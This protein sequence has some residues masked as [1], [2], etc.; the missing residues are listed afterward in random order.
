MEQLT[1]A[2]QKALKT[3]QS[4]Y[5]DLNGQGIVHSLVNGSTLYEWQHYPKGDVKDFKNHTQYYYHSHPSNDEDRVIEHGHFHVFLRQE[6]L[7]EDS[8]PIT[9]SQEYR[10]SDG[11]K[12]TLTHLFA[13]AMNE[14][15]FPSAFF[16]VN[17]WMVLGTWYSADVLIPLLENFK[18]ISSNPELTIVDDWLTAMVS[19]FKPNLADLLYQ[20]DRVIEE[21]QQSIGSEDVFYHRELEVTSIL[22]LQ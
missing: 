18:V 17:H 2:Q 5:Q 1:P 20:R 22:P 3:I 8:Q 10:D 6:M 21:K 11:N 15:G 19:L 16:T 9:T 4:I 13:I 14:Q 12:D 7:P